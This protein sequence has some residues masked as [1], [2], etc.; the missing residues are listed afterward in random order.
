MF[1]SSVYSSPLLLFCL[2][3]S[4]S[5][6][7]FPS[8]SCTNVPLEGL[9]C[10]V[11]MVKVP[12]TAPMLSLWE[13]SAAK[14]IQR[15]TQIVF[16]GPVSL[17]RSSLCSSRSSP[18][19]A[20]SGRVPMCQRGSDSTIFP[21]ILSSSPPNRRAESEL[22]PAPLPPLCAPHTHLSVFPSPPLAGSS[23]RPLRPST[24]TPCPPPSVIVGCW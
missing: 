22:L 3:S 1:F 9:L 16:P 12:T 10:L 8:S 17:R 2:L 20:S 6:F 24:H 4:S 21:L 7:C 15:A 14:Q 5:L 13:P 11:C 23:C 19:V 18:P